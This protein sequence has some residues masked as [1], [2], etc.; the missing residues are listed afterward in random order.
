[1]ATV[2]PFQGLRY[3]LSRIEKLDDVIAPPYDV[4]TA[5]AQEEYHRR[6]PYNVIRLELGRIGDD[7]TPQNNRYTR[8]SSYLQ[9]WLEE[10]VLLPEESPAL[11]SYRQEFTWQGRDFCRSSFLARVRLAD[12]G[13]GE[14]LPHEDTLPQARADR[15]ALLRTCRANFSPIFGLYLDPG[16]RVDEMFRQ[17]VSGSLPQAEAVDEGGIRHRLWVIK[18]EQVIR[19]VR[20]FMAPQTIY[21][22]DGHHRYETAL[23]YHRE[24]GDPGSAHVMMAL[25]NMFD[26]GLLILPTHRLVC[27]IPPPRPA[28]VLRRVEESFSVTA[29][30]L[31]RGIAE[32]L[33]LLKEAG[34]KGHAFGMYLGGER[35]YLLWRA[36]ENQDETGEGGAAEPGV[37]GSLQGKAAGGRPAGDPPGQTGTPPRPLDVPVLHKLVLEGILGVDPQKNLEFTH[38]AEEAIAAVRSGRTEMAF[39]LNPP[40]LDQVVSL[41][42]AGQKMPQKSTYFWPKLVTGL[43][44]NRLG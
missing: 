29:Y 32:F 40:T 8:A 42:R 37:P 7:D 36:W 16:H 38:Q 10:G 26:P 12:Y 23:Q 4:I 6:H 44:L 21:I 31:A 35:V 30:D 13:E 39:L 28:E 2:I 22:A 19:E 24:A 20:A 15:L 1:M 41:A 34:E 25:T 33:G 27:R 17:V 5:A 43:V 14:V 9:Q 3:D 18:E 11:Y